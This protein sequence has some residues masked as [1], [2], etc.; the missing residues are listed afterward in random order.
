VLIF[1]SR[2]YF[3]S[4]NCLREL[5]ETVRLKKS[6]VLVLEVDMTKVNTYI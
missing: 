3:T 5:A 6:I 1:L 4:T 2:G